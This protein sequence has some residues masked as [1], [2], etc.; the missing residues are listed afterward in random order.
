MIISFFIDELPPNANTIK[1][2]NRWNYAELIKRWTFLINASGRDERHELYH[3]PEPCEVTLTW[4]VT[5][6]MDLDNAYGRAKPVVDGLVRN[7]ILS[8]DNPKVVSNLSTP[9]NI[10]KRSETGVLIEIR[11]AETDDS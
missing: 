10:V 4:F 11:A 3:A 7:G 9:Q 6:Q 2:M 5:Q 8:D 1:R